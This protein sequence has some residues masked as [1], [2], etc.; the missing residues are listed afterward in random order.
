[1]DASLF[2][3]FTLLLGLVLGAG[4]GWYLGSRPAADGETGAATQSEGPTP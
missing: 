4:A 2:L 1:M 3:I